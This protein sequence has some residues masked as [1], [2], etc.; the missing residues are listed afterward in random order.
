MVR[1][2]LKTGPFLSIDKGAGYDFCTNSNMKLLLYT[3]TLVSCLI[4]YGCS[5]NQNNSL[6]KN[7]SDNGKKEKKDKDSKEEKASSSDCDANL[8]HFVY[9]PDRLEVLD[10]CK[11]VTGKITER[12]AD[13]DGDEHMLLQL[14]AGQDKLL[15]KKNYSK[16]EGCL[17]IEAVCINNITRKRAMGACKG[18]VNNVSLPKVGD[19]VKVTGSYVVDTHNGWTEIHPISKV[20]IIK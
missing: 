19:R 10:K 7:L 3:L 13:P 16:K 14:D 1:L 2:S 4:V 12:N 5:D 18:Y 11:T 9:D 20:E 17:V 6:V 15:K 8:W